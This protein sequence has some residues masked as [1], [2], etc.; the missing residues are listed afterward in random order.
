MLLQEEKL[1]R[2]LLKQA[3]VTAVAQELSVSR[4]PSTNG[5]LGTD[6][7]EVLASLY[8]EHHIMLQPKTVPLRRL[9]NLSSIRPENTGMME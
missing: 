1:K 7:L 2:I 8:T 4:Q 3:T 5:L 6:A 9:N